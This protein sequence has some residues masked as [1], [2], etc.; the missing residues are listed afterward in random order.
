[1]VNTKLLK[2]GL[3]SSIVVLTVTLFLPT[4][5]GIAYYLLIAVPSIPVFGGIGIVGTVVLVYLMS[6]DFLSTNDTS[7]YLTG[8]W[9]LCLVMGVFIGGI[10]GSV[11]TD[12]DMASEVNDGAVE[13]DSLPDSSEDHVRVL[14]RS[15]ANEYAESSMQEPRYGLTQSD[16]THINDSYVWSYGV[17]PDTLFISLTGNQNGALY[18]D[19]E[20]TSK[21]VTLVESEFTNGRGQLVVDSYMY[22][23]I[24]AN[25]FEQH[26]SNTVFNSE[27]EGTPYIAHST[28]S[29]DWR[30][31]LLPIPM[32]Y[33]VP[34]HATVH[35]M[36]TDGDISMYTPEEAS[37]LERLQGENFYPYA[38][39]TMRVNALQYKKGALNKWFYREDVLEISDL[40]DRSNDWPLVV[41]LT[42]DNGT[43]TELEYVIATEPIGEGSGIFEIWIID[44]QTGEMKYESYNDAQIGPQRSVNFVERQ[45]EINRLSNADVVAPIPVVV[46]DTLYWHT[47]VIS[48]SNSGVIY[49]AFVNSDSGDVV[50]AETTTEVYD[51]I[52][53]TQPTT[54]PQ[55]PTQSATTNTTTI[56]VTI[57]TETGIVEESRTFTVP[58]NGTSEI[59]IQD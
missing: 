53:E 31:R 26:R 50:L 37:E 5:Q 11:Y 23:S 27:H 1:M 40:P 59:T 15:V 29:H 33:A 46:D 2:Y 48:D 54:S 43:T 21:D 14:P 9:V 34:E 36:T 38:L 57:L 10:V 39:S 4:I 19:M 47:K 7:V 51:F 18:T 24:L 16:I 8:L 45:P 56:T 42:E 32:V 17:V 28:I 52:S 22:Q 30:F 35:V 6:R 12:I 20:Q 49:T 55:E 3:Y 13:L 44:G 25:P 41:P 58:K